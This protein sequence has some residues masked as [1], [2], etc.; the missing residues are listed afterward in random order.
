MRDNKDEIFF[1]YGFDSKKAA[2][3]YSS[4]KQ[5]IS[6][7]F[8]STCF[9]KHYSEI[10]NERREKEGFW[11]LLCYLSS[12]TNRKEDI[13]QHHNNVNLYPLD[14]SLQFI[15]IFSARKGAEFKPQHLS[16]SDPDQQ[17][18]SVKML[19]GLFRL[20]AEHSSTSLVRNTNFLLAKGKKGR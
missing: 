15:E 16:S 12:I 10:V 19:Y 5:E 1:S 6:N 3:L 4:S 2:T 13:N 17:D 20:I 7:A 14:C 8:I 9:K 11:T 18:P